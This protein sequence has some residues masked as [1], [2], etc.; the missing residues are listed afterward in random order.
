[1]TMLGPRSNFAVSLQSMRF[2]LK[3]IDTLAFAAAGRAFGPGGCCAPTPG[4]GVFGAGFPAPVVLLGAG[5]VG[6]LMLVPAGFVGHKADR[7]QF[8]AL[9]DDDPASCRLRRWPHCSS[10]CGRER[11]KIRGSPER[12]AGAAAAGIAA[13]LY[14]A[15][16]P[17]DSPL[18]VAS[19]Y[20]LATMIVVAVGAFAGERLLRW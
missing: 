2:D 5:V 12:L 19:W 18:F 16:C 17:D 6:E 15:N 1:M 3:F 8:D 10:R 20:P 14:A 4:S 11:R 7:Q 9:P 13:T